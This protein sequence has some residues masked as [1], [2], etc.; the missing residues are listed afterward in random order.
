L[1]RTQI[2]SNVTNVATRVQPKTDK[3]KGTAIDLYSRQ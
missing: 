2:Q 3:M 1:F